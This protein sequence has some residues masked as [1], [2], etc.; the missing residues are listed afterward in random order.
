MST[1]PE[2]RRDQILIWL[3][4]DHLLRIDELAQRLDV[5]NMTIHRDL[6]TLM[7]A[8][9]VE[10]VHGAVRLPNAYKVTTDVCHLCEMPVKPRLQ[11]MITTQSGQ[12][13]RACCAHCGVLLLDIHTD[14]ATVLLR[15]FLYGR[16]INAHQAHFVLRSRI[17]VCCEPSVLAFATLEDA[18]DFERG[19]GGEVL[20]FAEIR[21]KLDESHHPQSHHSGS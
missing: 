12:T 3:R 10:K 15:D 18:Q 4:A 21:H 11:F 13:L 6:D 5:S 7:A 14:V 16:M 19:F 9:L 2:Q 20:S 1:I 17:S 8:G